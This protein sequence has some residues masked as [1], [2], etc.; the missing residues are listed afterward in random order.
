MGSMS[1]RLPKECD[2]INTHED[3]IQITTFGEYKVVMKKVMRVIKEAHN[4]ER[5]R[6]QSAKKKKLEEAVKRTQKA[7]SLIAEIRRRDMRKEEIEARI[8]ELFGKGSS[9]EIGNA[10]TKEKIVERIEELSKREQQLDE[11]EKMRQD[12]K[13][14]QREDRRLNL[15]WRR[16]KTFPAKFGGDDETP[17]P[18]KRSTSGGASTTKKRAKG[19]LMTGPSEKPSLK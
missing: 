14:R 2:L 9:Q 18:K 5:K 19:G 1:G 10:T 7:K 16:N 4:V 8:E 13:R 6:R 12:A 11:W 3:F 17:D 15:F